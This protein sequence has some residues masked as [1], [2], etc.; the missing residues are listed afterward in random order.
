[1]DLKNLSNKEFEMF[2]VL[3][4]EDMAKNLDDS[5][6]IIGL[7]RMVIEHVFIR[8]MVGP[9]VESLRRCGYALLYCK[10]YR[11]TPEWEALIHD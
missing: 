2:N 11:G 5:G 1:M 4:F 6:D 7:Y 9:A 3:G 8:N 10:V